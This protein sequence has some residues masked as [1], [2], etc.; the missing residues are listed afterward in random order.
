MAKKLFDM[1][2]CCMRQPAR[3]V[4]A[5]KSGDCP[6]LPTLPILRLTFLA[7]NSTNIECGCAV[8][9]SAICHGVGHSLADK[10]KLEADCK[11]SS[12]SVVAS[13]LKPCKWGLIGRTS[14]NPVTCLKHSSEYIEQ[15]L[16]M[17][18]QSPRLPHGNRQN[19]HSVLYQS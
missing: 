12:V 9:L 6:L 15:A 13:L 2:V 5:Q 16:L 3:A 1:R 10:I 18:G 11:S 7:T 4:L 14:F 17:P 19:I 8:A